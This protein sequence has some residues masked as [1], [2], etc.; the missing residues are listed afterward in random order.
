MLVQSYLPTTPALPRTNIS[1]TVLRFLAADPLQRGF[2]TLNCIRFLEI[3][4]RTNRE[5]ERTEDIQ[6]L[7]KTLEGH[8]FQPAISISLKLMPTVNRARP[9]MGKRACQQLEV[10]KPTLQSLV[11]KGHNVV[12]TYRPDVLHPELENITAFIQG[13]DSLQPERVGLTGFYTKDREA[14]L[15][16][17]DQAIDH[18]SGTDWYIQDWLDGEEESKKDSVALFLFSE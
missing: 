3:E 6:K 15:Q 8:T 12:V 10:F 9:S 5:L 7:F 13:P 17:K 16:E 4:W 11:R 18:W 2:R 1:Y 14:W